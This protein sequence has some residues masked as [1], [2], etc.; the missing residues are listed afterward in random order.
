MRRRRRRETAATLA[1]VRKANEA[2]RRLLVEL[3][4]EVAHLT[5]VLADAMGAPDA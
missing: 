1:E 5:A 4:G 3:E 2:A